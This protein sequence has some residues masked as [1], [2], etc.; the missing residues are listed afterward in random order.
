L[1]PVRSAGQGADNG[2]SSETVPVSSISEGIKSSLRR[3]HR[4]FMV[5]VEIATDY[6]AFNAGYRRSD[7]VPHVRQ[8]LSNCD[9]TFLII[10]S[11]FRFS[12]PVSNQ[13]AL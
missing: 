9:F 12:I 3:E 1:T 2:Q 5:R 6:N 10:L 11:G 13:I 8:E 4:L 7:H